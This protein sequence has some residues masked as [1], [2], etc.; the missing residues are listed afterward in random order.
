MVVNN[1]HLALYDALKK[2]DEVTKQQQLL[3]ERIAHHDG[4]LS[5]LETGYAENRQSITE[6]KDREDG[7]D[8]AI[9]E[10]QE[11]IEM[12]KQKVSNG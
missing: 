3:Q 11:Y 12:G 1:E 5:T 7:Y 10:M 4:R 2:L 9:R 8:R 6:L